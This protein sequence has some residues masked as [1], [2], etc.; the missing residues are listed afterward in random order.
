MIIFGT[1]TR[2]IIPKE[3]RAYN[4]ENCKSEKTVT[5]SFLASY[6]HVFWIPLF[7]IS[8]KG[9]SQ[10]SH[11]KQV[12]YAKEMSPRMKENCVSASANAKRPLTHYFGL[13]IIGLV[14]CLFIYGSFQN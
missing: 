5:F 12:L 2:T 10:C 14:V 13:F 6:F 1:R 8:K 3:T 11:C 7:P 4:C 9:I